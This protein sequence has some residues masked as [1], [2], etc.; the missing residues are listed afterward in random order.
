[1]MIANLSLLL[2]KRPSEFLGL[3]QDSFEALVYDN[4]ILA[5]TLKRR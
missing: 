1:M 2:N 5:K 4:E 3:A